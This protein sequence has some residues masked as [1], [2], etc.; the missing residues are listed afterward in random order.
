MIKKIFFLFFVLTTSL[1]SA[2]KNVVIVGAGPTG[3]SAA[4]EAKAAGSNVVIVEK[5]K[6]YTREQFLFLD[7]KAIAFLEKWNVDVPM[8]VIAYEGNNKTAVMKI[9]Y[10]EEAL[11]KRSQELGIEKICGEFKELRN[12]KVIVDTQ[13]G[14]IEVPYDLLVAADGTHSCVRKELDI[15]V[16]FLGKSCAVIAMLPTLVHENVEFVGPFPHPPFILAK[17]NM[18][19][20]T[21]IFL[22]GHD[23]SKQLLF[24]AALERGWETEVNLIADE[25]VNYIDHVDVVFQQALRFSDRQNSAILLGDSAASASFLQGMGANTAF[26]SILIASRFFQSEQSQ[27]DYEEFEGSMKQLTDILIKEN[28][29]L[30]Q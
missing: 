19:C 28:S 1:F 5:R 6:C 7:D 9:K 22:Q 12:Q 10:L 8:G 11:C 21:L 3:L 18:P 26:E 23:V 2:P 27:H 20:A 13:E 24:T 14:I 25:K 16:H 4:F 17:V 15:P 29:Y 30:I